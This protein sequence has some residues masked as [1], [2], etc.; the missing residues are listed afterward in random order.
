MVCPAVG[1]N[2]RSPA[3]KVF[4]INFSP[5][6]PVKG[7]WWFTSYTWHLTSTLNACESMSQPTGLPT[8]RCK[9]LLNASP[10]LPWFYDILMGTGQ[11][12]WNRWHRGS[13]SQIKLSFSLLLSPSPSS[14]SSLPLIVCPPSDTCPCSSPLSL[15]PLVSASL[16]SPLAGV[17]FV[18]NLFISQKLHFS[19][20]T[21]VNQLVSWGL[22][23]LLGCYKH[24]CLSLHV[25]MAF[26]YLWGK[27]MN[28]GSLTYWQSV[29]PT[30]QET[31]KSVL[32]NLFTVACTSDAGTFSSR[33]YVRI[34]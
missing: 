19:G 18:C 3:F 10:S 33:G 6:I 14:S 11:A 22:V 27:Y 15:P 25:D 9:N 28:V 2:H 30:L 23:P 26:Y 12:E 8:S 32:K 1:W 16:W 29:F 5:R 17:D 20:W 31:G 34:A 7:Q 24:L 21:Y 4:P 13:N